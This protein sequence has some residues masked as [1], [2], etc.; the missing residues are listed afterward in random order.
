VR[1]TNLTARQAGSGIA[2]NFTNATEADVMRYEAER[3]NNAVD[4]TSIATILPKRNDGG[5]MSYQS[6]DASPFNGVNYYRIK[7]TDAFGKAFYSPVAKV[8]INAHGVGLSV[9]PN[10]VKGSL[11]SVQ[12][13]NLLKGVY[14]IRLINSTGQQVYTQAINHGGGAATESIELGSLA[15]GL[16]QLQ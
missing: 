16:Y 10:P 2:L 15:K 11:V 1:F 5:S 9:Y 14:T 6:V 7:S 13:S 3:S 4:F 8:N 12:L